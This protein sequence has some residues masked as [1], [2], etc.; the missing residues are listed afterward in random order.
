MISDF[1]TK[2]AKFYELHTPDNHYISNIKYIN[3]I[4]K[5]Y[6]ALSVLDV[7]CGNGSSLLNIRKKYQDILLDGFDISHDM[8]KVAKNRSNGSINFFI[9][10][11]ENFYKINRKYDLILSMSWV[12]SYSKDRKDLVKALRNIFN[13]LNDNGIFLC[14]IPHSKNIL[15]YVFHD[16]YK[17]SIDVFHSE[18][19]DDIH[20]FFKLDKVDDMTVKAIYNLIIQSKNIIMYEEHILNFCDVYY[21]KNIMLEIGFSK[22]YLMD[23]AKEHN[24][25][26][27]YNV[28]IKAYK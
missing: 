16:H 7:G 10:S 22:V 28:L 8:I 27:S 18:K 9:D 15:D 20:L 1:Y 21:I 5:K 12:L 17:S 13:S 23:N 6:N 25:N 11:M 3:F 4:I 14:E 24:I 26:S 2:F 19:I